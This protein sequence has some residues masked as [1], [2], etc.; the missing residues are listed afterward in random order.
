MVRQRFRIRFSKLGNLKFIGHKDLMRALEM[1][2]RRAGLPM[3]M[4]NGFH[5]K[6]RMSF[7]SALALGYESEDEVLEIELNESADM[8]YP[9]ALLA[10]LNKHSINGLT[11]HTAHKL[12]EGSK[13]AKIAASVYTMSIPDGQKQSLSQRLRSFLAE[14]SCPVKKTNGKMVDARQ[15]VAPEGD[16]VQFADGKLTVEILTQDGPEAGIREFLTA[17]GLDRELFKTVFPKK[18]ESRLAEVTGA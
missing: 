12:A 18:I 8:V 11:F 16:T 3:A 1:L 14:T 9:D 17:A 5:P 7:P 15:A 2:F 4:S 10:D 13:K 6:P